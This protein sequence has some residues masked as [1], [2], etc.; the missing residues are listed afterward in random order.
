M[1]II[2]S[3][4]IAFMTAFALSGSAAAQ[5]RS[6]L[7]WVDPMV[8]T[9]GMGHTFPG[10]CY[11]FG[12]V[13]LSPDTDT[14]P[15]NIDGVYQPE[16]YRYCAGY[17]YG[18][19]TIVG[20][21][22]TH[23][24][25][26]GHSDLG[27][28]L[29]MPATGPLRL[30]PGTAG[31]P[32]S[33][34]RSR[35][36]H[37]T[38][39]ARPG[40]Y[41]TFL[42]DYGIKARLTA[43]PRTGVHC[44]TYPSGAKEQRVLLDLIHGIY[45]YDGK[46]LWAQIRV[47][48][49][50][51]LTGYRITNGWARTNY[52]YFAISFSRPI[53]E[54]G[55]RE[56]GKTDYKGFYRRF[57]TERNFPEIGGRKIVAWFEFDHAEGRELEI[58]VAL[59]GVS[60]E[61]AVRNLKAETSGKDFDR[62]SQEAAQAWDRAL[63][64]MEAEGDENSMRMF[65]TSLYH[66]M[67]NPSVY[68]DVDGLYR[69]VDG[70]IH[71]AEGFTN[72]TVFSTWDTFRALHPLYNIIKRQLSK[73]IVASMIAHSEQSV[74]GALPV[75]SHHANENWCMTGY[76]SV[77]IL[78]DAIVAGIPVDT[79]RALK[80]MVRSSTIPYYDGTGEMMRIGYVPVEASGNSASVTLE[81]AYDDWAIYR[82]AVEAGED[83]LAEEYLKR[84]MNWRNIFDPDILH[85]RPRHEDGRFKEDFDLLST[86]GQGFIEG[87]SLNYSFFVPHDIPGLIE[88]MGGAGRF[89]DNLDNLFTMQLPDEF[90]A[91]TEDVTREG[92]LGGYVHG[93][94][95]SHHIVFLY[96]WTA[97]PWKTQYWQREI[98][99]RMYRP[100]IDGLCGNDDCGQM[101]AWYI[102]SA[103]GFYPVCPG[104]GEYVIGAPY[105]PHIRVHLENGNT[106]EILAPGVS[107]RNRYVRSVRLNGK[108]IEPGKDG[109]LKLAIGEILK[110][111]VLEFE[112]K[113]KAG[114]K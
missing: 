69:G 103:M 16:A 93:N 6:P 13:Q 79:A 49:D 22:H 83:D 45:N 80:A 59:S 48:N 12:I 50:T 10:A 114:R 24:S 52:T 111:G 58:K 113:G 25:G 63:S 43:T 105:M 3:L 31:E 73:D 65:Y 104:S 47:E 68:C 56:F 11:P 77:S 18:D 89:E 108:E 34:Y 26:T 7:G 66:T 27:D 5:S 21:S 95:P 101:S 76:H 92:I 32:G 35:Y 36:S 46:V 75:W 94:E 70:N 71:K 19:S 44:Y 38:E 54:Y 86:H 23:F 61:G 84:S 81:Y 90:F 17:Q 106:F 33:G 20:F 91:G 30:R 15:H 99:N 2:K 107:D 78:A 64:V 72:Y 41:E 8:G 110:G 112:M 102:F 1:K 9:N 14:V 51:L 39:T 96:S 42:E 87:N 82:T 29:L 98:M 55:Y 97:N 28:I 37:K 53:R 109:V 62:L 100:G 67:I 4:F 85:A 74:H 88:A 57:D 60:T 40:Y